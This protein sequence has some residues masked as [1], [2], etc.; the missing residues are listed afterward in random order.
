MGAGKE[1][2]VKVGALESLEAVF[3]PTGCED[4]LQGTVDA[5]RGKFERESKGCFEYLSHGHL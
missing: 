2:G 4:K 5:D 3:E 1:R